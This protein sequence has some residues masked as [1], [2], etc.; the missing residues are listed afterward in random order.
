M[1]APR[2]LAFVATSA[3][4]VAASLGA[5]SIAADLDTPRALHDV[6]HA[7]SAACARCHP[8]HDA[9]WRRTFHRTMTQDARAPGALLGDF[10]GAS[11]TYLGVSATM[12]RSHDGAPRVTLRDAAGDVVRR[13]TVERTVGSRRYQQLLAR[14]ADVY[15][16]L[17]IVWSVDESRFLSLNGVFLG[18]DPEEPAPG[19][20]G[21][22][23]GFDRH[24]TRWNDNCIFCHNVA[25][26]PGLD[27]ARGTFASEVAELGIACEACH[28]PGEAH[29]AANANPARR[30]ALHAS[31]AADPTIV[32]PARLD[33]T[34]SAEICGRCHGQRITP[35]IE[36]FLAHGDPFAPG[37][38]LTQYST[39]LARDTPL[40]GD[41]DAFADR[42]WSDGTARL[43]AYEFQGFLASPCRADAR[44]TCESCH[45]MHEGDPRGQLRPTALGDAACTQC[46]D[47][48]ADTTRA[49]AH[50]RH[51]AG[52]AGVRCV[53][54]HM[55]RIV[56]GLVDAHRSHRIESPAPATNLRD[57][58]P[59]ACTL[60]HVDAS[61]T[62]ALDATARLFATR[63]ATPQR[64][65]DEAPRSPDFPEIARL[66]AGGDP[67][68]RALAAAA[69]G[70]PES[71]PADGTTSRG[72]RLARLL[73][74]LEDE[75]FPAIRRIAARSAAR[76]VPADAAQT[77]AEYD[78]LETATARRDALS[79]LCALLPAGG[80]ALPPDEA[81]AT[82]SWRATAP[83]H[84]IVIGE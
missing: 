12:E 81:A 16:R 36:D 18:A 44:F 70:R 72:R 15:F 22:P 17:P 30:Y 67:I 34:R 42:F 76:L 63:D 11:F 51:D 25:P 2:V 28:G 75:R 29:A 7:T 83:G 47:A 9:S 84:A 73:R 71:A 68:E 65:V 45:A 1:T 46:H 80:C 82:A 58:R 77:L 8:A 39:P 21:V 48:F 60:C 5:R 27:A 55:P 53:D 3:L 54:C 40:G 43:T 61:R 62:W 64:A 59:D 31:D 35:R 23:P 66:L 56:Y 79:R 14:D 57:A 4:L 32:N 10:D 26:N 78:A 37:D 41:H 6:P 38:A 50:S 24:V 33:A 20:H 13:A 19:T 69:L 74:A 49:A 52:E